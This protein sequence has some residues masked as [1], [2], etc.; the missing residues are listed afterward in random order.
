MD[1]GGTI[2][3]KS[4]AAPPRSQGG[5]LLDAQLLP[6]PTMHMVHNL[7]CTKHKTEHAFKFGEG[8]LSLTRW[9]Q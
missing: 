7:S 4:C 9:Y 8:L 3:A 6:H 1:S 2:A 5:A